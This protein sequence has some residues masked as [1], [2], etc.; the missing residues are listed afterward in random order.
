M[1]ELAV[2]LGMFHVM[3]YSNFG[4]TI[5]KCTKQLIIGQAERYFVERT[6]KNSSLL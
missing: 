2:E 5:P 1:Y 4:N 3:K 6:P